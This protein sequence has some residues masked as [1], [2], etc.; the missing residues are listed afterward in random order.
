MR[1]IILFITALGSIVS[2][3]AQ[4]NAYKTLE[5]I[6][7]VSAPESDYQRDQCKMDIHYPSAG[8]KKPIILWF[9][10]GGLTGGRKEIPSFLKEKGFVIVGVGYR[11]AP[12]VKVDDI[13][14]DAAKAVSFIVKNADKYH[15]DNQQIFV[16]GHSAG[17]YLALMIALNK[18]YLQQENYDADKLAGI[19]SFSGQA[20][21]H[22]TARKEKGIDEKQPTIDEFAPL[23]WVRKDAPPIVLLSGDRELELLGRYEENAY[24]KRMLDIVGHPYVKL[25]ELGGYNHDMV[26]PGLPVMLNEV[27]HLLKAKK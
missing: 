10:G 4:E 2:L 12:Q 18:Q 25:V 19:I 24:L 7:Y 1:V 27:Q 17:G 21:T 13:I 5:N 20:V 8:G 14:K 23:Y 22:F 16:S 15:G 6:A 3:Y 9:H 11:F 26:Y